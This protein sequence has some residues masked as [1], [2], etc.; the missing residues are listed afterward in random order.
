M[1][2][3][4][5]IRQLADDEV[6]RVAAVL[7]LARLGGSDGF[8]LVAWHGEDPLGHAFLAMSEPP[9]IQDV[10]VREPHRGF[11]VGSALIRAAEAQAAARGFDVIRVTVSVDNA[12][13]QALYRKLLYFET[14]VPPRRVVGTIL[15]R[16]GSIEVDDTLLT[17]EKELRRDAPLAA[18]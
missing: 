2:S 18:E 15:I 9:E 6:D 13:A 7:G 8:Y 1:T 12:A 11:G 16:T 3:R 4:W 17:W 14:A 5:S 10:D